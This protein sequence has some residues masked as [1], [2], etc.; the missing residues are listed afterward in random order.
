MEEVMT[1]ATIIILPPDLIKGYIETRGV[2]EEGLD[3]DWSPVTGIIGIRDYF[4]TEHVDGDSREF[5]QRISRCYELACHGLVAM[6]D[7]AMLVHGSIHGPEESMVR[8]AHAWCRMRTRS[9][10]DLVWEPITRLVHLRA[11][12]EKAARAREEYAFDKV[13]AAYHLRTH[14]HTGPWMQMRYR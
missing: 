10:V 1:E 14:D 8:I 4:G 6:P 5:D 2:P 13:T 3:A 9:G 7:S 11:E 12:W